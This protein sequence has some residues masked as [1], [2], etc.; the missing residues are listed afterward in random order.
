MSNGDAWGNIE[1]L[2]GSENYH[3]WSFAIKNLLDLNNYEK[4]ILSDDQVEKDVD[5]LRKAK[6]RLNL[7]VT[8]AVAVHI[9]QLQTAAQIWNKLKELFED[10]GLI[11]RINLLRKLVT[12][13]LENCNSMSEYVGQVLETSNKLHGIGFAVADE[14]LASILLAGLSD[15]FKPMIMA[16]ESSGLNITADLVKSRL[17]ENNYEKDPKNSAFLSKSQNK[18]KKPTSKLKC[19]NCGK[20]GHKAA[21][22]R[23]KAKSEEKTA[24]K[25]KTA[26]SAVYL[27]KNETNMDEWYIDSGASY[28]MSPFIELF[29]NNKSSSITEITVANNDKM[30]VAG[31]GK[32]KIVINQREIEVNNVLH[33]PELSAN[34]L[35]VDQITRNG[36]K[37]TFNNGECSIYNRHDEC[38]VKAKGTDGIYK[39]KC[40]KARSL[41]SKC[42]SSSALTWHRRV[43]HIN[44]T[45][46]CRMR[47]GI[48]DG[49]KF[50][51]DEIAVKNCQSCAEGK[52]T[53]DSFN[54]KSTR[55]HN[56]LDLIHSDLCGPMENVS[57]GGA[58]YILTFIDDHTRKVF[59]YFLK[60]KSDV[61]QNFVN[62][63][64][65]YEKQ[66]ERN[67]KVLR[68][69]N[70]TEYCNKTFRS[71]LENHGI[72]HQTSNIHTPQQNGVAERMNRTII[73]KAKCLLF[74]AKLSKCYWAE[75]VSMAAYISNHSYNS[76]L[77]NQTPE[78]AWTGKKVDLSDLKI[79]G[80]TVM[81]YV[82]K[83]KRA[84]WDPN[85]RKLLFMGYSDTTKGYRCIDPQTKQITIS[86]DVIFMEA[87]VDQPTIKIFQNKDDDDIKKPDDHEEETSNV[88]SG[89]DIDSVRDE[90]VIID[91]KVNRIDDHTDDDS[92]HS[93]FDADDTIVPEISDDDSCGDDD[94]HVPDATIIEAESTNANSDNGEIRRSTRKKTQR[95][96]EGAIVYSAISSNVDDEPTT[97][98]E[99]LKRSD[100]NQW[101]NAMKSEYQSLIENSTWDLVQLPPNRKTIKSKWVYKLKKDAAGN[102]SKYKARFV[103]KGCSQKYGIDYQETYSP[104]VR[105]TTVRYL[106]ALAV[107]HDLQIDQLDAVTAFLQGDLSEDIYMEQPQAFD[108]GSGRICKLKKS[109]YGLKQSG[110]AWNQKLNKQLMSFKL[111]K[112]R[113]DPCVYFNDDLSIIIAVYVDDI[114]LFWKNETERNHIKTMLFSSFKMKDLGRAN[115]CVGINITYEENTICL[116]QRSYISKILERFNMINCKKTA[117][118]SDPSEKLTI[119]MCPKNSQEA[120]EMK[121]IPYQQ[122]VGSLLYLAQCTRPD[123]MFAINDVS[124]FNSNFGKS[125]W[126]GVKRIMRY[127]KGTQEFKLRYTKSKL[128]SI[129]GFSDSDYASDIDKRRSCTG[130]VFKMCGASISWESKRQ[131]TVATSS[132]EAE[133]LALSAATKDA[134]WLKSLTAEVD[135]VDANKP[136]KI[137]CDN[138]SA[139]FLAKNDGF[140]TRAKHI[141][142]RYHH[143]RDQIENNIIKV[144]YIPT[145]EMVADS[146]TKA[147]PGPKTQ[148]CSSKMGLI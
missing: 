125:H 22:C 61:F 57:I 93:L 71:Y 110:R 148:F 119:K 36:N 132:T 129:I 82:P 63:K 29:E 143:I 51:D 85:S 55:A 30:K 72:Q 45:D 144:D 38:V 67:I 83:P 25:S 145:T 18:N 104:V 10:K 97:Y 21:E 96:I 106:I 105:Y 5:K 141:D 39:I 115:N 88:E 86:R 13:Q 3:T 127:I 52:Q 121:D 135:K 47:D 92:F 128:N 58:R 75:A 15:E 73:E 78:E 60:S 20:K 87:E 122:A 28:H 56:K 118:P 27:S 65:M 124:R 7:S 114:L 37:V 79:F 68:S 90:V 95:V 59:V 16:M 116:D 42:S 147:V 98:E 123:I 77:K 14:W 139:I 103:A 62:F 76:V 138:Q 146:L 46:L 44:Y 80:A 108:D 109:I 66:I 26:F 6:A 117:T 142:V 130:Y 32:L 19:F 126:N 89:Y 70:G 120:E 11:R 91:D 74:N 101:L 33:V 24:E 94:T 113:V 50:E 1:K 69:D 35:S 84:K 81:V 136:I 53:R 8:P 111:K 9:E 140:N 12:T 133:Y 102:I 49:I 34:L 54:H 100:K 2:K 107:K 31:S 43:A 137:Y 40:S 64:K 23:S 4:C 131:K 41:L 112:S 48:V 17:L 99:V 134:I